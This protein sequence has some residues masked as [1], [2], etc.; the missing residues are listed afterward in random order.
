MGA[1]ELGRGSGEG[2]PPEEEKGEVISI[3]YRHIH[4]QTFFDCRMEWQPTVSNTNLYT[5]EDLSSP[6][7][8]ILLEAT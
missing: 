4:W 6:K 2:E 3:G 5:G 8:Y 1:V 7:D